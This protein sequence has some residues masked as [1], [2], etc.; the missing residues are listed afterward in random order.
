[1]SKATVN[2][3]IGPEI[4]Q[5]GLG[6]LR[7]AVAGYM[8]HAL[9]ERQYFRRDLLA[10]LSTAISHVPEGMADGLLVGVNPLYGLYANIF[11]PLVGG[12]LSSTRLMLVTTTSA[13]SIASGQALANLPD[14]ER[15]GALFTMVV[16]I[17]IFQI[18]AAVFK[19]GRLTRYV[20][21]SVMTGFLAGLAFIL[22][23]SQMPTA[24]GYTAT[25]SNKLT[26]ALDLLL[27]ITEVNLAAVG[28]ALLAFVL[29]V[30]LARTKLGL[31][32][33][34]IAIA[35]PSVVVALVAPGSVSLV[36]DIGQIPNGL[37]VF[38]L[39]PLS[40]L[41]T[42]IAGA[43]SIAAIILVQASGV[44]QSVPNPDGSRRSL[45][46]DFLS[47]GVANIVSGL[48]RGLPIGGSL[49]STAFS[50][51]AGG[52]TRWA[53]IFAGLWMLVFVVS[54]S[55]IVAQIAMPALGALLILA[56]IHSLKPTEISSVWQN[57]WPSRIAAVATFICTLVL[58]IQFAVAIG[59]LL[60]AILYIQRSSTDVSLVQL[61]RRDDGQIEERPAPRKLTAREVTVLDVYG[62]LFFA[63]AR[64]ME[65]KLPSVDGATN[66]A[67]VLRFRGHTTLGATLIEVLSNYARKLSGVKGRLYL[68]GLT[69]EA[70]DQLVASRKLD[71]T[72]PVQVF[73]ASSV[74]LESTRK[75]VENAQA[76]VAENSL[77][78][79]ATAQAV[80]GTSNDFNSGIG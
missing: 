7:E 8:E 22:I 6:R 9:P 72:G 74:V 50:L 53:A 78:T 35:V 79:E 1:V 60:S 67:V 58:P 70:Q 23:L 44:S 59:V 57:G 15:A 43:A 3:E 47:Q 61:V 34:L 26:Q 32:A 40:A 69:K 42:V 38:A 75:A 18:L 46:R 76:W 36:S 29:A 56:G 71:L 24:A 45:S 21:Y 64:T 30:V 17:G 63:G 31:F 51:N 19:L 77:D 62:H 13:A 33:S 54:L 28:L 14:E 39:P 48:F 10:G 68:S 11:G 25:G 27:H 55:S 37:P 16:L 12:M 65:Q 20:S 5:P 4:Q 49:S 66:A 41:P 52:R 2:P 80:D 73:P